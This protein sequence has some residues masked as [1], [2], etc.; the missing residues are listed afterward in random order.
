MRR[1]SD[2]TCRGHDRRLGCGVQNLL[3]EPRHVT[4]TPA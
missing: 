1:Y 3:D 2:L 4:A